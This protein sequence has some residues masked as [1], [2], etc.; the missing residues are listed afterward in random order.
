MRAA[1]RVVPLLEERGNR[2]R[3]LDNADAGPTLTSLPPEP[4]DARARDFILPE[5]AAVP[6]APPRPTAWGWIGWIL[7]FGATLVLSA[8]PYLGILLGNKD[9]VPGP[10]SLNDPRMVA[11]SILGS[12]IGL[13]IAIFLAWSAGLSR[14]ELGWV[15]LPPKRLA[16][17][18]TFTFAGLAV[19]G[20]VP[21]LLFGERLG[22]IEPLT[23]QP[24]GLAH[25][26]LWIG[27]ATTAGVSEEFSLRGYAI[28]FLRR[29]GVNPWTAAIT[30]S[31]FFGLLHGYEGVAAVPVIAIW[32]M[33]F[34]YS[35]LKT[36]SL[37]PGVL[38]HVLVDAIAPLLVKGS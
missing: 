35:F 18:T 16:A 37:L 19:T 1:D 8:A 22:I 20:I 34:A 9:L 14:R 28:G 21:S 13:V 29:A 2:Q 4:N 30:M 27:L 5:S 15:G 25:W 11:Y 26:L 10:G 12:W 33:L 36:G 7:Y 23:R 24:Q 3:D 17:W 6:V 32:G 31:I 38:A